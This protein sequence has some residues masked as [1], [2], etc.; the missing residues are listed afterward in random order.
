MAEGS[1]K[2]WFRS[3]YGFGWYPTSVR[4]FIVFFIYFAYLFYVF[5]WIDSNSASL[6]NTLI[7]LLPFLVSGTIILLFICYLTGE[8][9]KKIRI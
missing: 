4:G 9:L 5:F 1:R 7:Y 2:Y 6:L 3:K 8:P